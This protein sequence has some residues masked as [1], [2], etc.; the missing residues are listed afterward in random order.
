VSEIPIFCG[1]Y[2]T[3]WAEEDWTTDQ[4]WDHLISAGMSPAGADDVFRPGFCWLMKE[5][6]R[7]Q[8]AEVRVRR[9]FSEIGSPRTEERR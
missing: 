5:L 8:A 4:A 7:T 9:N 1:H 2:R 3:H 6:P